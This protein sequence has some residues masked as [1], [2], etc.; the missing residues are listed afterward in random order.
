MD[1]EERK[2]WQDALADLRAAAE[3]LPEEADDLAVTVENR[4]GTLV[5]GLRGRG[6]FTD[7]EQREIEKLVHRVGQ[8]PEEKT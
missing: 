5:A 2:Y 1:A 7:L 4:A 8:W 3:G 6:F